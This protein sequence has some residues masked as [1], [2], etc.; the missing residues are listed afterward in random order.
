MI[1]FFIL[2]ISFSV[3]DKVN[4][5]IR[6][7]VKKG[8]DCK[9]VKKVLLKKT[10]LNYNI[11]YHSIDLFDNQITLISRNSIFN[12]L[13]KSLFKVIPQMSQISHCQLQNV[14]DPISAK[15]A[16]Y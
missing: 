4:I 7:L 16:R 9:I 6:D 1:G 15:L 2:F 5:Y 10:D 8:E 13:L 11:A 12:N 3:L 14:C